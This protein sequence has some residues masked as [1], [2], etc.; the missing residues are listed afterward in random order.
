MT[1][2]TVRPRC[3]SPTELYTFSLGGRWHPLLRVRFS[4]PVEQL[5]NVDI[6]FATRPA[7]LWVFDEYFRRIVAVPD[8]EDLEGRRTAG[9]L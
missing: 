2:G 7:E 9:E 1:L 3:W 4:D 8:L 6:L 5:G